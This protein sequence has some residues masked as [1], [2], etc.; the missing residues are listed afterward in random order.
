MGECLAEAVNIDIR[1]GVLSRG[2][3]QRVDVLPER[4]K[5]AVANGG[6]KE[7]VNPVIQTAV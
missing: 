6:C 2:R 1:S 3:Y 7:E 5:L 4:I